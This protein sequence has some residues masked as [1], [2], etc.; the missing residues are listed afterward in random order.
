MLMF[1]FFS[2]CLF[3]CV[4]SLLVFVVLRRMSIDRGAGFRPELVT[5]TAEPA[6]LALIRGAMFFLVSRLGLEIPI[7]RKEWF[8]KALRLHLG[9][10]R[11]VFCSTIVFS[12]Q[13]LVQSGMQQSRF[14][15]GLRRRGCDVFQ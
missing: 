5:L 11:C 8:S 9:L 3:G 12:V 14:S 7:H 13:V 15:L 6:C 2:R 1:N 10:L 4:V